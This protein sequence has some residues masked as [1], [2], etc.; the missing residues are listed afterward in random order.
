MLQRYG[1]FLR[2][3]G[4]VPVLLFLVLIC[5]GVLRAQEVGGDIS[6]GAGIFRPKNPE[7]KRSGNPSRPV[8]KPVA[9]PARPN[10]A[11]I[12][13][14]FENAVA[15]GNDARDARDFDAAEASYRAAL[16]LKPRDARAHYGLGNVFTD[17]QRWDDAEKSYRQA[18]EFAPTNAEALM[19]LSFVLVQP[20]TGAANAKRFT[21]AE[22][23]A[24]RATQLEP[25]SAVAFDRLG[26]AMVARAIINTDTEAA[27]RK[28]M[29]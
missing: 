24:R 3:I 27:F 15:D 17:Q 25:T 4:S 21:D 14:K 11:E 20:R 22:Y 9:R 1:K 23:F 28:A 10:P 8:N 19:A 29:E 16:K 2:L 26:V 13:E 7:A 5:S 12:E 6:G 18:V